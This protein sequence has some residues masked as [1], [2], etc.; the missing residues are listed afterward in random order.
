LL[1][2]LHRFF[3]FCQRSFTH[4]A[5]PSHRQRHHPQQLSQKKITFTGVNI[6]GPYIAMTFDDG[7]HATNTP[8]LLEMAAK[9]H[10]KLT[11]LSLASASS[12]T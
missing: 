4:K 11:F 5:R 12:K 10:I 9:S 6:D 8:R 2:P 3:S 1:F 7:P